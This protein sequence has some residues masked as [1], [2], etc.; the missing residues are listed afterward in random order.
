MGSPSGIRQ[1]HS[2]RRGSIAGGV[3]ALLWSKG[4]V[5]VRDS[6]HPCSPVPWP[7]PKLPAQRPRCRPIRRRKRFLPQRRSSVLPHANQHPTFPAVRSR[8]T[9]ATIS[10]IGAPSSERNSGG[11]RSPWSSGRASPGPRPGRAGQPM[12]PLR[13]T[14]RSPLLPCAWECLKSVFAR[15]S[16]TPSIG[17]RSVGPAAGTGRIGTSSYLPSIILRR[18]R[19]YLPQNRPTTSRDGASGSKTWLTWIASRR[20]RER[21]NGDTRST[22]H[23]CDPGGRASRPGPRN[24]DRRI[25]GNVCGSSLYA[26]VY[27]L[28]YESGLAATSGGCSYETNCKVASGDRPPE[29]APV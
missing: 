20:W 11:E 2:A 4:T 13:H 7:P 29:G 26:L 16:D 17:G 27:K 19:A 14:T 25:R 23:P 28:C 8:N 6:A 21:D 3:A 22:P 24:P 12:P 10:A 15:C 18:S 1:P 5:I 9:S